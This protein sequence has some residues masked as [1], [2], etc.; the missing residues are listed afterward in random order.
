M[1]GDQPRVLTYNAFA[2][3]MG[4]DTTYMT[5]IQRQYTVDFHYQ[6]LYCPEHEQVEFEASHTNVVKLRI[7]WRIMNTLLTRFVVPS[8][9]G[10]HLI[11]NRG[12]MALH[13]VRNPA[14][15]L[16]LGSLVATTFAR[17]LGQNRVDTMHMRA[18]SRD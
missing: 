18:L 7:P 16:P 13:S 1:L 4:L 12:L 10:G 14:E 2:Q 5:M 11:T 8:L 17:C 9:R 6:A 3:A 15:P